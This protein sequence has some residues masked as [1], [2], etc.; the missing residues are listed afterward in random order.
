MVCRW[1]DFWFLNNLHEYRGVGVFV[2][3]F[4]FGCSDFVGVC[5]CWEGGAECVICMCVSIVL[6]HVW[7]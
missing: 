3:G 7:F 4:F 2:G 6:A 5:M 1:V